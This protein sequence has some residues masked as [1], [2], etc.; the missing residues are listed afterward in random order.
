MKKIVCLSACYILFF[1]FAFPAFAN[2]KFN[3]YAKA[4]HIYLVSKIKNHT[5]QI[6]HSGVAHDPILS[7]DGKWLAFV[8]RSK[9]LIPR[10]CAFSLTKTN[11]ADEVWIVNLS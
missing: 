9:H 11:Y 2:E 4:G 10:A 5:I 8:M 3:T 6:T 7:P 1:T